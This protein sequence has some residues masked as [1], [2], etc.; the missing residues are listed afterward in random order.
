MKKFSLL[1]FGLIYSAS[2]VAQTFN[3]Q[4]GIGCFSM[5]WRLKGIQADA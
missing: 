2:L 3:L 1:F 4:G 5:D